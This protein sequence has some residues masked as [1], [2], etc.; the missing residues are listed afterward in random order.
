MSD[1][2]RGDSGIIHVILNNR[3]C[4]RYHILF[5]PGLLKPSE[6]VDDDL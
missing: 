2:E 5:V 1:L 6:I 3:H 4:N